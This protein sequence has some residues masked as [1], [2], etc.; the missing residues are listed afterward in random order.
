MLY[1]GDHNIFKEFLKNTFV[2]EIRLDAFINSNGL[3][4]V[5]ND[6]KSKPRS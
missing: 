3:K 5:L 4:C 2:S 6:K 1:E